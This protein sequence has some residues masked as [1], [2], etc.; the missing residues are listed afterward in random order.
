ML[1]KSSTI[2][3]FIEAAA[4]RQPTPG[5]GSVTALAG[6][7]AAAMGEMVLNYS[8]GK[9]GLETHR[10]TQEQMLQR[11]SA[12]RHTMLKRMA[13]DQ[14]S[15]ESLSRARKLPADDPGREAE[16][17]RAT[18]LCI[19]T[20]QLV[21][22]SAVDIVTY[23]N[24]CIDIANPQLLSDLAVCV[25]LAMATARCAVYNVRVNLAYIHDAGERKTVEK[26]CD[27]MLSLAVE[28]TKEAIPKIWKRVQDSQKGG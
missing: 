24:G 12:D 8:L 16:I 18:R 27:G 23:A 13:E 28:L 15:F 17:A 5:G 21:L 4:A 26:F 1:D 6:A 10:A 14:E 22:K 11:F 2:D 25:E 20:P 19:D 9:K 7:L 3:A